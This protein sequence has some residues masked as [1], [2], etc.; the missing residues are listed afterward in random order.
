MVYT[1]NNQGMFFKADL[2]RFLEFTPKKYLWEI[3]LVITRMKKRRGRNR[4]FEPESFSTFSPQDFWGYFLACCQVW[5]WWIPIDLH[6]VQSPKRGGLRITTPILTPSPWNCWIKKKSVGLIGFGNHH[7]GPS[8][9]GEAFERVGQLECRG[10]SM[11][12]GSL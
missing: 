5:F 6:G 1:L 3:W 11:S 10:E 2:L 12:P 4:R 8:D 7:G 9:F